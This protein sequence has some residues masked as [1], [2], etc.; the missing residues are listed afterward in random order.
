MIGFLQ[1]DEN[2]RSWTRLALTILLV[3]WCVLTGYLIFWDK[4][5]ITNSAFMSGYL[6]A[7]LGAKIWSKDKEIK[8]EITDAISK[9]KNI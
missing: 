1:D 5:S 8:V 7:I 9:D 6:A 4:L 3:V 2:S